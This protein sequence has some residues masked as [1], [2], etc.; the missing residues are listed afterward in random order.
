MSA[1]RQFV[2]VAFALCA[3]TAM[4]SETITYT[5]DS[6][7]RLIQAQRVGTVNNGV[8]TTY[9]LDKADN[10]SNKTTSTAPPAAAS[11]AVFDATKF[12]MGTVVFTVTKTG[13]ASTN[14]SV[15]YAT[16]NGTAIASSDYTA[17]SG[18]LTF[19]PSETSKTISVPTINDSVVESTETF[20][21]N[22]SNATGGATISDA[23]AI[24]TINDNDAGGPGGGADCHT[25][26]N[27]QVICM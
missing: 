3:S 16:A 20:F 1:F 10:R 26:P 25:E 12:E 24:G 7:G 6:Q 11:F 14:L 19:L 21:L 13:S 4:A 27:G 22:L 15:N 18:T 23:Q 5:Y 17:T 2:G 9:T 8:T